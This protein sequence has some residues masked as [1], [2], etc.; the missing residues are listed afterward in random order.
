[1][2]AAQHLL[3]LA[4]LHFLVE[5]VK[6]LPQFRFDRLAAIGPLNEHGEIVAAFAKRLDQLVLLFQ[7]AAALQYFLRFGLIVPEIRR[8]GARLETG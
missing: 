6:R 1:V 7:P 3:D 8:G 5:R 4:G 2:F